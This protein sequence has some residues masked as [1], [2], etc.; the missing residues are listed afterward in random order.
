MNNFPPQI[1]NEENSKKFCSIAIKNIVKSALDAN[2]LNDVSVLEYWYESI[3]K[4]INMVCN[5]VET[6]LH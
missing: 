1:K 2:K 5:D 4:S 3:I 6:L